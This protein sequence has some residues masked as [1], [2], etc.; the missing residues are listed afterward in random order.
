MSCKNRLSTSIFLTTAFL[1]AASCTFAA[2]PG[3]YLGGQVGWGTVHNS[4]ISEGD[5]GHMID[6]ALGN[7]AFTITSFNGTTSDSGFAWRVFGGYQIGYNWALEVGWAQFPDLP[8]KA[9]ATGIDNVAGLPFVVNT[10]SGIFKTTA[11]D[12]VGK[13]IYPFPCFCRMNVYGKL[14][15]AYVNGRTTPVMAV[16]EDGVIE[17]GEDVIISD[18]VFPTASIGLSFDFRPDISADLSYTRIQKVGESGQLGSID[19]LL[20]AM[21]LHFG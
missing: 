2:Q 7:G 19:T 1:I 11:F 4:G 12:L 15:V 14:G 9:N 21:A 18:R 10:S 6:E 8:I 16:T 5:M 3:L 20:L 17:A 13:Y